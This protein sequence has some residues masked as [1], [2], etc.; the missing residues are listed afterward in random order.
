MARIGRREALFAAAAG[1]LA[2]L[3][4]P[5]FGA[6]WLA[7]VAL[8]PLFL[9]LERGAG[10]LAGLLFGLAF[11]ALDLRW[12]LTLTRFN[13]LLPLGFVALVLYLAIPFGLFGVLMRWRARRHETW[14]WLLLAP[15][16]FVLVEVLRA[17]GPL[18]TGFSM[19][20]QALYRVPWLIQS[21]AILGSWSI[22]ALIVGVNASFALAWRTRRVRYALIGVGLFLVQCSFALL[23]GRPSESIEPIDVAVVASTV[24]QEVKLDGRNLPSLTERYLALT[25]EAAATNSD[26][27]VLPESFLPA[28]LL[29]R[30]EIL[31]RFVDVASDV[32]ARLLFGTGDYRS[33]DAREIYNATVLIDPDGRIAGIYDMVRPVPFGEYIPARSM[34]EAIGLGTWA[35]SLLPLDLSR[36]TTFAPLGEIGTPICFESTFPTAAR[37][38]TAN[39][40]RVLVTVTND[41]W[42]DGSSELWAHFST[43]VFRA[44]ETRRPTVQAANG[45]VSGMIDARG[46]I[47]EST[48]EEGV[49]TG[50]VAP[51]T[52][53]SIYVRWGDGPFVVATAILA[54]L[55]LLRRLWRVRGKR[56]GE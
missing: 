24:D 10:F 36:G 7:Y 37:R 13:P 11:F 3:T 35:R 45:G 46:H 50:R 12:I 29:H 5:G 49:L 6:P 42:F 20:H 14:A 17:Q 51:S 56:N 41:A 53:A 32:G 2:A 54:L 47:V 18:G 52:E 31:G 1:I 39:G 28:Y 38:L 8:V 15:T 9:A 22:T 16:L 19:L 48:T 21:A 4:M 33:D 27:I 34:L 26:L 40:A 44:V 43:A 30:D 23:P 55:G 25:E